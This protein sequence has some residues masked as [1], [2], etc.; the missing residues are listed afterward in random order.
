MTISSKSVFRVICGW[1]LFFG[2]L[3]LF[4]L[5]TSSLSEAQTGTGTGGTKPPAAT[6]SPSKA[7]S[8]K[9][10]K[11]KKQA[12]AANQPTPLAKSDHSFNTTTKRPKLWV[13]YAFDNVKGGNFDFLVQ[14]LKNSGVDVTFDKVALVPGRP[15]WEQIADR[16]ADPNLNGWAILLTKESLQS[17]ACKEQLAYALDRTLNTKGRSFPLLGLIHR[18]TIQELPTALRVRS[19]VDLRDPQ[20]TKHVLSGLLAVP[21][22]EPEPPQA[23][24]IWEK[25]DSYLGNPGRIALFVRP[26]LSELN[27]WRFYVPSDAKII[28][29]GIGNPQ[30]G[31]SG[32]L[33]QAIEGHGKVTAGNEQVD[34]QIKGAW[35]TLSPGIGAVII[36]EKPVPKF[37]CFGIA[38]AGKFEADGALEC[39]S[40]R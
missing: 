35:N 24:F 11:L 28:L 32:N 13:T 37:A 29:F 30:S 5:S 34:V 26:R 15:L 19:L 25:I 20:W 7:K 3:V 14:E 27:N 31:I 9:K 8:A 40:V 2:C 23:S 33:M 21:L 12:K 38:Q 16:I 39:F 1:V 18:V 6:S 22:N 36:L 17:E 10:S 4:V